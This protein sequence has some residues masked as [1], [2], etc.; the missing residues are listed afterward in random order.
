M[1]PATSYSVEYEYL[2]SAICVPSPVVTGGK[3]RSSTQVFTKPRSPLCSRSDKDELFFGSAPGTDVIWACPDAAMQ[4]IAITEVALNRKRSE[5][6][7]FRTKGGG[8]RS[9]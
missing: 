2:R 5:Y 1:C 6:L 9:L 8:T 4:A 7:K 3:L